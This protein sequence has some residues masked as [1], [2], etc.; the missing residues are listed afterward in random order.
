M[1]SLERVPSDDTDEKTYVSSDE[2]DA[3]NDDDDSES[4]E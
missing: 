2:E 4:G 3:E 1:S